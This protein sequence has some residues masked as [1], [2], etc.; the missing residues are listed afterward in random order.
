[1]RKNK[2]QLGGNREADQR[3]FLHMQNL[4]F[5]SLAIFCGCTARFVSDLVEN[6]EDR[7][8]H[9][10]TQL[11]YVFR[12]GGHMSYFVLCYHNDWASA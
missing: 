3:L 10:T 6:P 9:L 7:F 11:N 5:K 8:S 1:M 4:N 12:G 2:D